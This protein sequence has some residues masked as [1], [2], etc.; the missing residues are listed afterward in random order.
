MKIQNS[1][2]V[3]QKSK[4][5]ILVCFYIL[6]EPAT[7]ITKKNQILWLREEE[8]GGLGTSKKLWQDYCKS[9]TMLGIKIV[10]LI[11]MSFVLAAGLQIA[12]VGCESGCL[13]N[14]TVYGSCTQYT[15]QYWTTTEHQRERILHF[16]GI[17][18]HL[19]WS[20]VRLK[21][22]EFNI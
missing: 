1:M 17:W 7:W 9:Q 6:I 21:R 3:S 10:H 14:G 2:D 13:A 22:F 19:F 18:V 8:G 4:E 12:K 15:G 5:Y 11:E 16:T 20:R